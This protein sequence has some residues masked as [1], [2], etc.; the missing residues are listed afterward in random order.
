MASV[1][2]EERD[3]D[4][5]S[6]ENGRCP[7]GAPGSDYATAGSSRIATAATDLCCAVCAGDGGGRWPLE[8]GHLPRGAGRTPDEQSSRVD[9][10]RPWLRPDRR[11]SGGD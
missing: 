2:I 3:A 9:H 6:A 5:S 11:A 8:V 10:G 4:A 7:P 1:W